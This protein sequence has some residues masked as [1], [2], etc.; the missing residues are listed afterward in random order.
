MDTAELQPNPPELPEEIRRELQRMQSRS[1]WEIGLAAALGAALLGMLVSA[2][3]GRGEFQIQFSAPGTVFFAALALLLLVAWLV[4]ERA[5]RAHVY[6]YQTVAEVLHR[7]LR[8]EKAMR[9]PLTS[10]YNR[11]ALQEFAGRYLRRA[12]RGSEPLALAL[13]DLDNFHDLNNKFGHI[14]GDLALAEFVHTL[15]ASTRGSDVVAR[16]GGDEFV[17]MLAETPR[18]GAD[19]VVHRVEERLRKRNTQ[20]TEGQVPLSASAGTAAYEKGMDFEK[21]FRVADL[22]LL[23]RKA[24]RH[25]TRVPTARD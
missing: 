2:V 9:D 7:H 8:S 12:E 11:A 5:K 3:F 13:F 24:D 22:D 17:I 16:Y 18:S 19:I 23:R 1:P 6:Q 15:Q 25:G 14:A 4:Q 20:L 21:L 10:A